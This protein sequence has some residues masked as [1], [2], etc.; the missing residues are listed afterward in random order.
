MRDYVRD[1]QGR[2]ADI[3]GVGD[4]AINSAT[5][6]GGS[7]SSIPKL[8]R[9]EADPEADARI[10]AKAEARKEQEA[11]RSAESVA[12]LQSRAEIENAAIANR[13]KIS[14]GFGNGRDYNGYLA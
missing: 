7:R 5:T 11:K 4:D 13:A 6:P 2:F 9:L 3:P 10:R 8:P 12:G 14:R 1:E